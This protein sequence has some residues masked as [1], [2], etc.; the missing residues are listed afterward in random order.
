V[1]KKF[2]KVM[3]I[4]LEDWFHGLTFNQNQWHK[5]ERRVEIVTSLL[6]DLLKKYQVTATFFILGDVA[7]KFP[8]LVMEIESHGHEIG[9]HGM[10][11]QMLVNLT[12]KEFCRDLRRSINL[13]ESITR[14]PVQSYRAPF[15]SISKKT[16]WALDILRDEG[17]VYDS[18]IF[19]VY[20]P[21]YGIPEA[22][23]LPHEILTDL[24]E[25]PITTIP[26]ILGNIPFSGGFYFRFWPK[27]LITLA[28]KILEK[29]KEPILFYLHPWEIDK[30][31]PKIYKTSIYDVIHYFN[32]G[33]TKKLCWLLNNGKYVSLREGINE[34]FN[35]L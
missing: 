29:K 7:E 28:M 33:N 11:H 34:Y 30:Y 19:P 27:P 32:I 9:S 21:R 3:T 31:H 35:K 24:W 13:L 17:I 26:F 18:S 23:R 25:W 20:N 15:F 2:L 16:W 6:L 8:Q 12:P 4:D 14:K 1:S 10:S 5:L 22:T